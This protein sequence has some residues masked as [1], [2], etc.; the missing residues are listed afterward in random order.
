MPLLLIIILIVW[1]SLI[2]VVV[3][4]SIKR[5]KQINK[6]ITPKLEPTSF[7]SDIYLRALDIEKSHEHIINVNS[8]YPLSIPLW[9]QLGVKEDYYKLYK[10]LLKSTFEMDNKTIAERILRN[11]YL[12]SDG[13]HN[14]KLL[15]YGSSFEK[16]KNSSIQNQILN[17]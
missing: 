12:H 15:K 7:K 2:L 10:I 11:N 14:Y 16:R 6:L 3:L 8:N 9:N 5:I 1:T 13:L 17:N 4:N